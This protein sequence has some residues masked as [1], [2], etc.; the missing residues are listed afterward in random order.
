MTPPFP[1]G[2][3]LDVV[4]LCA[5]WCGVCRTY[6]PLFESLQV[7]FEGAARFAWLDIEE[8]SELLG[9]IEVENFP[10][11]L[12]LQG[13]T[14]LFFGPLTPQAGMLTQ[15]VQTGLAGRLDPLAHAAVRALAS[16]VQ[17]HLG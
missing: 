8:E 10:T 17:S 6:Q 4:C 15:L 14:P 16:L 2:E 12:L 3:R 11:L 7:Q 13:S 1:A 5:L 9:E